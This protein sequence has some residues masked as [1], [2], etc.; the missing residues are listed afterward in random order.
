MRKK[1]IIAFTLLL[2]SLFLPFPASSEGEQ[3]SDS[4]QFHGDERHAGYIATVGPTSPLLA[5]KINQKCAS[6]IASGERLLVVGDLY[7][8]YI[9]NETSGKKLGDVYRGDYLQILYPA[10]GSG[11]IF[12]SY[13]WEGLDWGVWTSS[14]N[15]YSLEKKWAC[16]V[17]NSNYG[18]EHFSP[19]KL[20]Y[21]K[22]LLTF[23]KGKLFEACTH[24]SQGVIHVRI[25]SSCSTLWEVTFQG[26]TISTIPTVADDSVVVGFL[27]A[28]GIV[29]LSSENGKVL[30]SFSTDSPVVSS[31]AYST[32]FYF[33]SSNGVVYAVSKDGREVW[34]TR[35][36][37]SI[38]TTPAVA[39][40]RVYV[41]AGDGSLYALNAS[42]G[43][44]L[45]K[46]TTGGPIVASPIVSLNGIVY[47]GSTDGR[48]YA[49]DAKNGEL[50][51]S[52][53][54]GASI[55]VTPVLDN[56]M[57]FVCS[58]DGTIRAYGRPSPSSNLPGWSP[59]SPPRNLTATAGPGYILLSWKPPVSS[60]APQNRSYTVMYNVFRGTGPGQERFLAQVNGT[61]YTD[62]SV[63]PGKTYYYVVVAVNPAGASEFS[64]EVS[65]TVLSGAPPSAV[66]NLEARAVGDYVEL[67][68]SP[69]VYTGGLPVTQYVVYRGLDASQLSVYQTLPGNVTS[70]QDRNV[71]PGKTY[72]YRVQAV[73]KQGKGDLSSVVTVVAPVRYPWVALPLAGILQIA[74]VIGLVIVVAAAVVRIGPVFIKALQKPLPRE[75]YIGKTVDVKLGKPALHVLER[76]VRIH[77]YE[78]RARLGKSRISATLLCVD[79]VGENHVLKIPVEFYDW[80]VHREPIQ[81]PTVLGRFGEEVRVLEK[82]AGLGHPCI[83]EFEKA[84]EGYGDNPPT[85]VFEYCEGGSLRDMVEKNG[86]LDPATAVKIIV[87]IA[88]ALARIHELG[89]AHGDVKPENI[90]F[91]KDRI[92]KLADFNS[93]RAIASTGKSIVPFT[94]GFAAPEHIHTGRPSQKGDVWS[95]ALVLYEAVTGKSLFSPDERYPEE[96]EQ[97]EKTGKPEVRTGDVALDE[98]LRECIRIKPEARPTMRQF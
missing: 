63:E 68:W 86:R 7:N 27:N 82:V 85:L 92:P 41:G 58:S 96:L 3:A 15:L 64:N 2:L 4:S 32:N 44:L 77:G 70:F 42:N 55:E 53:N 45:W 74:I 57:L 78:C 21:N 47:V 59:S 73:N 83:V 19:I 62:F 61:S 56:G 6:M 23:S 26:Y 81:R 71:E 13:N 75:A 98:I 80:L 8:I 1:A 31:P 38:E 34:H 40:G 14:I 30:W 69:P 67:S 43:K 39:F 17:T 89:Y 36:G 10:I 35:L 54:T 66:S 52:D 87:Q 16:R 93:A 65:A 79:N 11:N 88:D 12:L 46:Y 76:P 51:W 60:G 33:G 84:L 94:Y 28:L 29:A 48:I 91:T 24:D 90:L 49:L 37:G 22:I 18:K 20:P 5:W 25:P 9:L 72:Y 95:L 50:V 97:F